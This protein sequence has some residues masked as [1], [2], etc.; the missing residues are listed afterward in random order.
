MERRGSERKTLYGFFFYTCINPG[1]S[2]YWKMI[3]SNEMMEIMDC[4][5]TTGCALSLAKWRSVKEIKTNKS[6]RT[7][8]FFLQQMDHKLGKKLKKEQ[9]PLVILTSWSEVQPSQPVF[10]TSSA[11][12][13]SWSWWGRRG[14][15]DSS[16]FYIWRWN[17]RAD[18]STDVL[19]LKRKNR[20]HFNVR[21]R[22]K[23]CPFV[24]MN[25]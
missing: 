11:N 12:Q 18:S 13:R 6:H 25:Y 7:F 1:N 19:K 2:P 17:F 14:S 15:E 8:L 10:H 21:S 24:K 16:R 22:C 5:E 4:L 3:N 9:P 23:N 20:H